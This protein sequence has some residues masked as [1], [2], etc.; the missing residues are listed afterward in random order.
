MFCVVCLFT[1]DDSACYFSTVNPSNIRLQENN[2]GRKQNKVEQL[3][4]SEGNIAYRSSAN[5]EGLETLM[6][7]IVFWKFLA[8]RCRGKARK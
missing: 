5:E 1:G 4:T 7:E 3:L 8:D 6:S 2:K